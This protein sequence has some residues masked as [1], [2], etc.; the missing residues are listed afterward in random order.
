MLLDN[1]NSWGILTERQG[2]ILG[3]IFIHK[4]PPSPVAVIGP[5][6]VHPS[7]EGGIDKRL[8]DAALVQAH[9]QNH[10]QIRLVQSPSH[11]RSFVLYTK[12]G[13]TL[14]EPLFLMQGQPPKAGYTN[15]ANLRLVLDDNDV[16]VC[17][18]L[19]KSVHGFSREMELRQ[20]K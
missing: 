12:C 19:C 7:A 17:N 14:R 9:K 13:F 1:P 5:L 4:F 6:T 11:I 8:M 2:T 18:E 3:S 20:A 10:D 15:N 16:S